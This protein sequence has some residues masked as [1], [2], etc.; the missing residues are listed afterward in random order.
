MIVPEFEYGQF[1]LDESLTK[2]EP[3]KRRATTTK[4]KPQKAPPKKKSSFRQFLVQAGQGLLSVALAKYLGVPPSTKGTQVAEATRIVPA[5]ASVTPGAAP[6]ARAKGI[7]LNLVFLI[8]GALFVVSAI[9][10]F[11]RK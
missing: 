1:K 2:L 5:T 6:I 9:L 10:L 4:I 11:R 3:F 7:P 8:G